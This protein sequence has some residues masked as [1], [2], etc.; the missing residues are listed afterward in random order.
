MSAKALMPCESTCIFWKFGGHLFQSNG[1]NTTPLKQNCTKKAE[2]C[3][4]TSNLKRNLG[5]NWQI[6]DENIII[7]MWYVLMWYFLTN[8]W[9]NVEIWSTTITFNIIFLPLHNKNE[10]NNLVKVVF[11]IWIES[12][13]YKRVKGFVLWHLDL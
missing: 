10:K 11:L 8:M 6:V 3:Q 1:S 12:F 13:M 7:D 2:N 4:K 9:M 5:W